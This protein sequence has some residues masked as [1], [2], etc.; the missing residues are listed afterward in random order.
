[1]TTSAVLYVFQCLAPKE[2]PLNSGSLRPIRIKAL[3]G[4]L[5][6]AEYPSA[7]A[8]G[9]VETSQRIVDLVFG[10]LE[11]AI[12]S[13]VPAASSGSMSNL[14]FGGTTNLGNKFAY[15]ETIAGGMGGRNGMNGM[16]AV[17]THMTNTLNTPVEALERELPVMIKKYSIREKSG[18][19]GKFKGGD[20]IIRS[21]KFLVPAEATLITER[22]RISPRGAVGGK[23]GKKGL[24]ILISDGRRFNLPAKATIKLKK[25]DILEIQ[26]PGGGAWGR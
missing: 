14:T 15:Y 4:S 7:V 2:L 18:G 6:N 25:N 21:Y 13:R 12:P 5:L 8:G 9:N 11:K 24:N 22:R 26:S 17:Q 23:E 19:N 3:R 1:M 16:S 10:A 20:G